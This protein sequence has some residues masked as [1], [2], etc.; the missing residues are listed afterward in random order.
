MF[1]KRITLL[2]ILASSLVSIA[3]AGCANGV[4][5]RNNAR[6]VQAVRKAA[7]VVQQVNK[8]NKKNKKRSNCANG[9]CKR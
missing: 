1:L 7:V 6:N 8:K 2:S 5:S 3:Q 4:C 9:I